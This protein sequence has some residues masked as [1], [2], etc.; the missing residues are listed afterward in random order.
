MGTQVGKERLRA[1]QTRERKTLQ[2]R[3]EAPGGAS[4]GVG[5]EGR[6]SRKA[7]V[8]NSGL[9]LLLADPEGR[10]HSGPHPGLRILPGDDPHGAAGARNVIVVVNAS[11][12]PDVGAF[13]R[14]ANRHH[15]LKALLVRADLDE[16][17]IAHL[18]E[19]AQLRTLKN[20]FVSRG[21][22]SLTRIIEAWS[23]GFQDKLIADAVVLGDRLLVV[24][25]GMER[26]EV[27]FQAVSSLKR[28]RPADRS[29]FEID[30]D[31]SHI[32]WPAA[33]VHLDWDSLR[34]AA[35]G[36]ARMEA[37]ADGMRRNKRIGR[38]ISALRESRGIAAAAIVGISV[39]QLRRIENGECIPRPATLE[40]LAQ[41]HGISLRE[42]LDS[43][44]DSLAR[45]GP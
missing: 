24:S 38:A 11:G 4:G 16:R 28:M 27:P 1:E 10:E 9:S 20:M 13:V 39:R 5:A 44:A 6:K 19:R 25:C 17:W 31:G 33:D 3:S 7:G 42:Y 18:L 34:F 36:K 40:K 29:D 45:L 43:L 12:L 41:A 30:S 8:A 35:D 14:N 15:H 32:F 2:G 23:S 22:E 37:A 21:W 26:L